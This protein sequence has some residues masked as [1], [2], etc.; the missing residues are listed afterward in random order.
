VRAET[1]FRLQFPTGGEAV[2]GS[3]ARDR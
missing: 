3:Q 1:L 2:Q